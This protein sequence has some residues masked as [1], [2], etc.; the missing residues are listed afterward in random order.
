MGQ[1]VYRSFG[2]LGRT[3][4]T[5]NYD[6]WLDTEIPDLKLT[7]TGPSASS[8]TTTESP[9]VR[10]R[11]ISV[12]EFTLANLNQENCVFYLHGSL[13]EPSGMVMTTRDYIRRYANDRRSDDP[14][15]ENRTLTFLESL[16]QLKTVLFVGYGLEDLEIL[17]YVIQ[18]ARQ[19]GP[20]DRPQA[21]HFMLQGYFAHEYELMRSMTQY[22]A[23]Y[24]I[25]LIPFRRDE[26][27]WAQLT[28]VLEAFAQ[29]MPA[30]APLRLQLQMEMESLLDY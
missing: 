22:Y 3:F 13:A 2:K 20:P 21:R 5:T 26:R 28:E 16:F 4:V 24:D 15:L 10:R 23:Q 17:E 29:A 11:I 27:N 18:K 12:N 19:Q 30:K 25:E 8:E 6:A 9:K 14:A 7:V 1:R